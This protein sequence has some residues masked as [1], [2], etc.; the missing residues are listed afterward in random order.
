MIFADPPYN[1]GKNF[2]IKENATKI[3]TIKAIVDKYMSCIEEVINIPI[4]KQ[5]FK[6]T[7]EAG[8]LNK[9]LEELITQSKVEFNY[10]DDEIE[11]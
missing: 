11:S 6:N 10:T 3:Y 9:I 5:Q 1:I 7:V 2:G 8:H 4:L